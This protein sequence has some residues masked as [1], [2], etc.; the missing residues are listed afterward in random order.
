VAASGA[1]GPEAAARPAA[2]AVAQADP[3][4]P[5]DALA[6]EQAAQAA[7]LRDLFGPLPFRRVALAPAVLAWGDRT[8]LRLAEGIYQE[9]RWADLPLLADALLDA[10]CDN[11]EVVAHLRGPGPHVRGCWVIDLLTERG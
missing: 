5:H 4:G 6:G 11:D 9:R 10:G 3:G 8:V 7:L 2:E 1:D